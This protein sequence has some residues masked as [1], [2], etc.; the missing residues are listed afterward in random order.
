MYFALEF[1]I[2]FGVSLVANMLVH[3]VI[4]YAAMGISAAAS[5]AVIAFAMYKM[6]GHPKKPSDGENSNQT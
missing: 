5:G 3:G 4:N 6:G 1:V 2:I